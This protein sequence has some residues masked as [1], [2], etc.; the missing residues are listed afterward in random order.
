[1][2][3]MYIFKVDFADPTCCWHGM[4]L[5]DSL[6]CYFLHYSNQVLVVR[7]YH[8][9]IVHSFTRNLQH[10]QGY[11]LRFKMQQSTMAACGQSQDHIKV[12]LTT[13]YLMP[14]IFFWKAEP[15][16]VYVIIDACIR[17]PE[18][19]NDQRWKWYPFWSPFPILWSKR[20]RAAGSKIRG[21]GCYTWRSY[22][23]EV[24]FFMFQLLPGCD[25]LF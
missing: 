14:K 9:R 10:V 18:K 22:T 1:M 4:Q 8:T 23:S 6:L 25:G 20:F 19:A 2:Q 17:G 12:F 15:S 5:H 21:F 7:L 16:N 11:G 13:D 3:S 24:E